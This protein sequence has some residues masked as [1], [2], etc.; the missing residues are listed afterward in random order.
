MTSVR[1]V[2]LS[3]LVVSCVEPPPSETVT[4][5][6]RAYVSSPLAGAVVRA[7]RLDERGSRLEELAVSEP[8][9]TDGAFS[10]AIPPPCADLELTVSGGGY[11]EVTGVPI[12]LDPEPVLGAVVTGCP[13]GEIIVTPLTHIATS[14]AR[15][16][17]AAEKEPTFALAAARAYSLI[18]RHFFDV[19]I[20]RTVPS[21]LTAP[22]GN[23]TRDER[24]GLILH[25]LSE[26]AH[27][28]AQANSLPDEAFTSAALAGALALDVGSSEARFDGIE[29]CAGGCFLNANTTRSGLARALLT[30][31]RDHDASGAS[32]ELLRPELEAL[33]LDGNP[34]L[35]GDDP[36]GA[37]DL[38]G[39]EITFQAPAAATGTF[40]LVV[41]AVDLTAVRSLEVSINSEP[42][43]ADI[44]ASPS[45]YEALV[46]SAA[47]PDGQLFVEAIAVDFF[48]TQTVAAHFLTADNQP[49]GS[50]SGVCRMNA[51]SGGGLDGA[52]VTVE[53]LGGDVLGTATS[54]Q[55]GSFTVDL[56]ADRSG[57][58]LI[59]C[60]G[61]SAHYAEAASPTAVSFAA[62]EHLRAIVPT[63]QVG[64]HQ[65]GVVITPWTSLAVALTEAR[66]TLPVADAVY[67]VTW[68]EA[69]TA[70]ADHLL[71]GG[72]LTDEPA[73]DWSTTTL[74]PE[75]RHAFS[76]A[77]LSQIA[78]SLSREGT[79]VS[80]RMLWLLLERDLGDGCLDG[81]DGAVLPF[82]SS[83]T[84]R[85][86]LAEAIGTYMVGPENP[87]QIRSPFEAVDWLNGLS[88]A[89][90]SAGCA[91]GELFPGPGRTYLS[92]VP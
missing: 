59:R 87:S 54:A 63:H 29:A 11:T 76:L 8:T 1:L 38:D 24:Y 10:L 68:R 25:G 51:S 70:L 13:D 92:G 58:V 60:G 6:G 44:D 27:L 79:A 45:R 82:V 72:A 14:L 71:A 80:A 30:L 43:P 74:M 52:A 91:G 31:F 56:V 61:S 65:T 3:A 2:L 85:F 48:G 20:G 7:Y 46:D 67:L 55:D 75:V 83:E 26:E 40:T 53:D 78:L 84:L 62:G 15:A 18:G 89:G 9:T 50:I 81:R 4:V 77:G 23:V 34:E 73:L 21:P 39:P 41:T 47:Y 69:L 90:S 49:P 16:R 32:F 64:E 17:L 35:Y 33:R 22:I 5:R 57:P 42:A 12:S 28:I 37:L 19:E 86:S 66:L 88:L 36:V